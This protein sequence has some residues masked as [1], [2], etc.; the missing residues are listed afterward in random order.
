MKTFINSYLLLLLCILFFDTNAQQE[1]F[2]K[3]I[4]DIKQSFKNAEYEKVLIQ[5][6]E[7]KNVVIA[8]K[9]L[10]A[11]EQKSQK[12]SLAEFEKLLKSK[13]SPQILKVP[14]SYPCFS[15]IFNKKIIRYIFHCKRIQLH[16]RFPFFPE[17]IH[18]DIKIIY[19]EIVR[20]F[21]K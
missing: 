9:K 11:I 3:I 20:D 17:N 12:Y 13:K 2:D 5:I 21:C 19:Q 16:Y 14:R 7:L 4:G 15:F 8:K 18:G 10:I 1:D 6:D